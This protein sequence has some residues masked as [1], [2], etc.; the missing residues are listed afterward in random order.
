MDDEQVLRLS[1]ELSLDFLKNI[2][3]KVE[4]S[5][6]LYYVE[7]PK[8]F[9]RAFGSASKR[10]TFDHDVADTHSCELAV[11]GSNFLATILSEIRKQAPVVAG[12]LKRQVSDSGDM[13]ESVR[14]HNCTVGLLGSQ[15]EVRTAIRFHFNVSVKSVKRVAMLR[16]VDVDMDTLGVLEFPSEIHADGATGGTACQKDDQRVD[17]SYSK[18]TEFLNSE[19]Q[20]LAQ[21]CADMTA[22]NRI[23][24]TNSIRQAYERRVADIKSDLKLQRS[25]MSEINRRIARA[26]TPQSR[27]NHMQQKRKQEARVAKDEENAAR[28]IERLSSDRDAQ[29]EQTEKRYRPVV[30]F[31]LIAAQVYSYSSS[32]C[33]LEFKNGASSRRVGASFVDPARSFILKCDVCKNQLDTA[34]LCIN[35]HLSCDRCSRHCVECQK[36][37]C[38]SCEGELNPCHICRE[39][40]CSDCTTKC[41]FCSETTCQNHLSVCPHCSERACYFCSDGCQVCHARACEGSIHACSKCGIRLC[42]KD[43]FQCDECGSQFCPGDISTCAICDKKYCHADA[44]RCKFCEQSYSSGC[45]D[46]ELCVTCGTLQQ[47]DKD[48]PEV[49]R[50]IQANPDMAKFK[51]WNGSANNRFSIFKAKKMLG[52]RIIV[53]DRAQDRIILDKKAGWI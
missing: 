21:K 30:E 12:S 50:V 31:S 29:I 8:Q 51:K 4:E 37:V 47:L 32:Q 53:Y 3:A 25:K 17:S 22:G 10:I 28:Q 1:R 13:L 35:S 24:D 36:D 26:R 39:G 19:M 6:R 20:P 48:S 45:L 38:A 9:E 33:N 43:S 49:R 23:S 15:E 52:S 40:L 46:G 41:S 7:V 14:T 27:E 34:H 42:S 2:G 5:D 44:S 16:W 18:A 11:P